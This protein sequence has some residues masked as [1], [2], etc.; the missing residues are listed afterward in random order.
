MSGSRKVVW[1][2]LSSVGA[3]VISWGITLT[4]MIFMTRALSAAELGKF[5]F[6]GS[7]LGLFSVFTGLGT[8]TVIIRDIGHDR[9]R[10]EELLRAG[11]VLRI[12]L[13]IMFSALAVL[14]AYA[15]GNPPDTMKMVWAGAVGLIVIAFNEVLYAGLSGKEDIVRQSITGLLEKFAVAAILLFILFAHLH[16]QLWWF[17]AAG[18]AVSLLIFVI[19]ASAFPVLLRNWGQLRLSTVKYLV[20]A[21]LPFF[22][23]YVFRQIYNQVDATAIH[24]LLPKAIADANV[25]W[26]GTSNKLLGSA[27]FIPVALATVLLPTLSRLHST[28]ESRFANSVRRA[29]GLIIVAVIPIALPIILV[30]KF[31]LFGLLHYPVSQYGN[32]VPIFRIFGCGLIL[33]YVTQISGLALVVRKQET[34]MCRISVVALVLT[35]LS[36]IILIPM[37]YHAYGNGGIG[38]ALS[39]VLVEVYMVFAFGFALPRGFFTSSTFWTILKVAVAAVPFALLLLFLHGTLPIISGII[40]GIVVYLGLC[41]VFGCVSRADINTFTQALAKRKAV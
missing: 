17:T 21:G 25:G 6:V 16:Y 32:S 41:T 30:P 39:D 29:M 14:V 12:P 4:V 33:W 26:Y 1:N 20:M 11:I 9:N 22:A 10:A 2:L 36:L 27:I 19:N 18:V 13:S 3:Q 28:D 15:T 35:L 7:F 24:Y 38:A 23:M 31:I 34:T 8:A 37:T 5:T 40:G